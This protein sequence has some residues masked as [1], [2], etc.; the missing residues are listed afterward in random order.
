[1]R[2]VVR[3]AARRGARRSL[4]ACCRRPPSPHTQKTLPKG[5][6]EPALAD[7]DR[8]LALE[9]GGVD[10][11]YHRGCVREKL[12]RLD[13]AIADFSAVLRLDPNHIKASYARG[14]ARNLKGDFSQ[15][16][17]A[18]CDLCLLSLLF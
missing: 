3:G 10:A 8:A 17:G 12:G 5:A 2:L 4:T 1:M 11:L 13:D 15:A 9:P 16:I 7:Y 14:A 6:L 18:F